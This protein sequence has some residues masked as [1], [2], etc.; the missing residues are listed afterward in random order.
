M[1]SILYPSR[2]CQRSVASL[3]KHSVPF[4][5]PSEIRR[6]SVKAFCTLPEAVRDPSPLCQSILYPSRGRQRSVASLSKHSV[7]FQRLSE[8][9]R[10]SVKALNPTETA[11]KLGDRLGTRLY[12]LSRLQLQ[13]VLSP[14]MRSYIAH[15]ALVAVV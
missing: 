13:Q 4:H 7:P 15:I 8:I 2:G 14:L 11:N 6:P 5:R 1:A 3:S 9:R 10:L 12:S